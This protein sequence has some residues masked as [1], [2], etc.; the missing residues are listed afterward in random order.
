LYVWTPDKSNTAGVRQLLDGWYDKQAQRVFRE[1]LVA[2]FPRFQPLGIPQPKLTIKPLLARWG[3]CTAA[4]AISLNLKLIQVPKTC[5]DYVIIHELCHL[6][7]HNH[8]GRFYRLLDRMLPDWAE[9]RR[10]LN[11][12]E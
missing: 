10:R 1:R 3:S 9:R 11:E 5:I 12:L 7:E 8:S 2:T 4:G 6:I